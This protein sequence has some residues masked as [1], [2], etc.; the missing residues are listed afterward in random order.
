M[1]T[2]TI[3][4]RTARSGA[5][6]PAGRLLALSRAEFTLLLRNRSAVITALFVPLLLP[7]SVHQG[8]REMD[9]AAHGLS[10]GV[11]MLTSGI[12][13]S[14]LFAVYATLVSTYVARRE[15][16]VLKRLRTGEASDAEILGGAAVPVLTVSVAQSLLMG[17]VCAALLDIG[18]PRAPH[19]LVLGVVLG[20]LLC[21]ALGAA[22]AGLTKTVE[23]SQVSSLPFLFVTLLSSGMAFPTEAMPDGMAAVC[24]LL[25]LS[26]AIRLIRE[27]W[28]G[29]MTAGEALTAVVTALAWIVVAVFAVRRWFRWDP[30]R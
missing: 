14:L 11:M 2:P 1:S 29:T 23:S 4:T 15:E 9:L 30:R 25:P 5:T 20:T 3:A 10:L 27:G 18:A 17:A 12:G 26:P 8:M 16:L 22:T 7:F 24:D 21:A 6:T 13:F 28:L 19:L